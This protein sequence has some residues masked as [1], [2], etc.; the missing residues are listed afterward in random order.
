[1]TFP[2]AVLVMVGGAT[3]M[4]SKAWKQWREDFRGAMKKFDEEHEWK[5]R[6]ING[7]D[8]G[9]WSARMVARSRSTRTDPVVTHQFFHR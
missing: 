4:V 1:M 3:Y 7:I 9:D 5:P 6:M 8:C 2:V